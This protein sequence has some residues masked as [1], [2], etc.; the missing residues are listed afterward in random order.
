M[1]K[2]ETKHQLPEEERE[3]ER[4]MKRTALEKDDGRSDSTNDQDKSPF[5]WTPTKRDVSD[6]ASRIDHLLTP[7]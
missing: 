4:K 2:Q 3:L 5:N 7:D 1:K 6:W